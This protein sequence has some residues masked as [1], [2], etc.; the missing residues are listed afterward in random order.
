MPALAGYSL[1]HLHDVI[2]LPAKLANKV[3]FT[4]LASY[5]VDGDNRQD[6]MVYVI[7]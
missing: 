3:G 2:G 7:A 4:M 5:F 6:A 1:F